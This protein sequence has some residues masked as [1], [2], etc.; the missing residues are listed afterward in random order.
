M[1]GLVA[2]RTAQARVPWMRLCHLVKYA[3]GGSSV[4][5]CACT[6]CRQHI[7]CLCLRP[8]RALY[9][10]PCSGPRAAAT[11]AAERLKRSSGYN[12]PPKRVIMAGYTAADVHVRETEYLT[13][14][15]LPGCQP[16]MHG[17]SGPRG[18]TALGVVMVGYTAAIVHVRARGP[19]AGE[20]E[21]AFSLAT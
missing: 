21:G 8:T 4:S 7:M 1:K 5:T 6:S 3:R 2:R 16:G 19:G 12:A 10:Y 20:T 14:W 15:G 17:M 18:E 13:C 11:A 9:P